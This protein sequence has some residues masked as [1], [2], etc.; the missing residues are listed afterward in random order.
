MPATTKDSVKTELHEFMRALKVGCVGKI[1]V[2][3]VDNHRET[4]MTE[5]VMIFTMHHIW[6][7]MSKPIG[8][9]GTQNDC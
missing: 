8:T 6:M 9:P 1:I 4:G 7:L 2:K 3:H 5:H